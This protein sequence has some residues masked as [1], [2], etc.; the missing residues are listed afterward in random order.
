MSLAS[1]DRFDRYIIEELLG[2]GGMARVYRAYDPRLNRRVAL[3]VLRLDSSREPE[4]TSDASSRVLREARAAAALDHPNAVSVFDVGEADG[5]LFISMEL[6]VGKS[7]RAYVNDVTVRWETKL[8]WM[9]DAARALGAAHDR[10]LVHRDVKPENVMVRGDG[11]VKVLDFGIAKRLRVDLHP[12]TT[13][14]D[15]GSQS[16]TQSMQGTIV[17]TP[18]YLSPEQL[19]GEPVDGR[20]DQ[21][22]WGVTTYEL[23]TGRLPWPKGVDG[24]Q[25]VL[26]ILNRT[27]E[28]PS[29]LLPV[30]PS[31][32]EAAIMK[33]LAKA[34]SQRFDAM[35]S[36]A[37]ALEGIT[38]S[39]RRSWADIQIAAA[40]KT[41]PAPPMDTPQVPLVVVPSVAVTDDPTTLPSK[42]PSRAT[43]RGPGTVAVLGIAAAAVVAVSI[44]ATRGARPAPAV[45]LPPS[46]SGAPGASAMAITDAPAPHTSVPE[47]LA[48]Y[49][50]FQR[51]FRDADWNA[52][53]T[54]LV[55]ATERDPTL[56]AG[57]LRLAFMRS[58]ESIDEGSVRT[59]FMQAVRNRSTLDERD[60]ALLE[61]LAPYLQSDPSDPLESI[62]RLAELQ[63]RRPLDAEIAYLLGSVRYDRGDLA[64]ALEAFDAAIAIDREFALA[65]S[66]KGG[67]LLYMGRFDDARASLEEALRRSRTATE[68]LWYLSELYEQQGQCDAE[69]S[70]VRKWLSRDPD[71]WYAYDYLARALA[72][73]G[74]PA[75]TVRAALEQK[76]ARLGKGHRAKLEPVDRALL[77]LTAGDFAEAEERLKEEE[78]ALAGEPGAQ[79]H[80]E[81]HA[82]LARIAEETG[83]PER[84]R[85]VAE[86]YLAR[87]DA[88]A[89][90]HRVD[91]VSIFLDPI[92]EMLGVLARTGGVSP[93]QLEERRSSWLGAWR[94]KTSAAYL[95]DLWI[96]AWAAPASSREQGL[97]AVDAL[98]SFGSVP[99]FIPNMPAQALVGH[100][101]LLADRLDDA[102][103]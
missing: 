65:W 31:I 36:V 4:S 77:A 47:A 49:R 64:V 58:L 19:R 25:L 14:E 78:R 23:L 56:A 72:G 98:A 18:W 34:P 57:H 61:A 12:T 96:A 52:A 46:A 28:P 94:A 53:M 81:A 16:I 88:W 35:E 2:E 91:N 59:T 63:S 80:A 15:A 79:A 13:L 21:F 74:K 67:C 41:D 1:G 42:R 89:P 5:Q 76:W 26:A 99:P 95:G 85:A 20:T 43:R 17:G 55:T 100:A 44:Y 60:E 71:D 90:S 84:A 70:G 40:A 32:V 101:Y 87:K 22:A 8:R 24:F 27:P 9:V 75:D 7:L 50:S 83:R 73:E 45:M 62:R 86:A 97:A 29:T 68:P 30:L 102:V 51:S 3:K 37:T 48:A 69:E 11:V 103:T 54:A 82:L 93:A 10:G 6:V 38:V 33:A 66:S 92:P 39:S